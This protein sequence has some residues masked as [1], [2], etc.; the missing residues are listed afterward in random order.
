MPATSK[1]I[2]ASRRALHAPKVTVFPAL[3]ALDARRELRKR[4]GLGGCCGCLPP[5]P[6]V[7]DP[8]Q[9]AY[10]V[11]AN[12]WSLETNVYKVRQERLGRC[13]PS[14]WTTVG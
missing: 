4:L 6:C 9:E 8:A 5:G 14:T 2:A 3:L 7:R 11:G 13:P 1:G 12:G 10:E